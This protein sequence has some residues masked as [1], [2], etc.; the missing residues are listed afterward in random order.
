M[1]HCGTSSKLDIP[2]PLPIKVDVDISSKLT[3]VFLLTPG[4]RAVGLYVRQRLRFSIARRMLKNPKPRGFREAT[5]GRDAETAK[6]RPPVARLRNRSRSPSSRVRVR[7]VW[8]WIRSCDWA[9]LSCAPALRVLVPW[10]LSA[11]EMSGSSRKA[12][13]FH[14]ALGAWALAAGLRL[15]AICGGWLVTVSSFAVTEIPV[16]MRMA[17][18]WQLSSP[19]V[20]SVTLKV[21]PDGTATLKEGSRVTRWKLEYVA[22]SESNSWKVVSQAASSEGPTDCA[23]PTYVPAGFG[24]GTYVRFL[25]EDS[26]MTLCTTDNIGGCNRWFERVGDRT[27]VP[28]VTSATLVERA[29]YRAVPEQPELF[30]LVRKDAWPILVAGQGSTGQF[31][32]VRCPDLFTWD[33]A[34]SFKQSFGELRVASCPDGERFT[35]IGRD[36][37][38][39]TSVRSLNRA[40]LSP[41][42]RLRY[43]ASYETEKMPDGARLY[44]YPAAIDVGIQLNTVIWVAAGDKRV[45]VVQL[46]GMTECEGRKPYV[47]AALCKDRWAALRGVALEV[48]KIMLPKS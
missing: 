15:A 28:A 22:T 30:E 36:A 17:G 40:T 25:S 5:G 43:G 4:V 33:V 47:D 39:S 46:I 44:A 14:A 16:S 3:S 9:H 37:A 38:N 18:T 45:V 27:A 26:R 20:C 12:A 8:R 48:A 41:D 35:K 24:R 2:I 7:N 32:Q 13:A 34:G 1:N 6:L 11:D 21:S 10:L 23:F 42:E 19:Q 31:E 29:V